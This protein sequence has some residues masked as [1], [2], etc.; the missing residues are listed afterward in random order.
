MTIKSYQASSAIEAYRFVKFTDEKLVETASAATDNIIGATDSTKTIEG[1]VADVFLPGEI[2]LIQAGGTFGAGDA[3]TSDENGCA[4]KA[5]AGDNIGAIALQNAVQNDVIQAI[6]VI[7]RT[8]ATKT[9][10]ENTE[11][12]GGQS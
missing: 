12:Q 3:L 2:A 11:T 4:I 7:N 8:N 9:Q 10:A 6:V 1:D 5:E